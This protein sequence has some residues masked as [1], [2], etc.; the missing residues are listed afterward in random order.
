[1]SFPEDETEVGAP[2][3]PVTEMPPEYPDDEDGSNL[4]PCSVC[5]RTFN[6]TSLQRHEKVCE[7]LQA[8]KRN[9]FDSTKQRQ[10]G[11]DIP[12]TGLRAKNEK[13]DKRRKSRWREKHQEFLR[14]IRAAKGSS[15][16]GENDEDG[17][18]QRNIPSDYIQ[19]PHCER[20]FGPKAADRHISWCGEQKSRLPRT[21]TNED[22][23]AIQR[24]KTRT[25]YIPPKPGQNGWRAPKKR[26]VISSI[27]PSNVGPNITPPGRLITPPS[28]SQSYA[29]PHYSNR[30]Q[31]RHLS[32]PPLSPTR[33]SSSSSLPPG[34][35]RYGT[36]SLGRAAGKQFSSIL[37]SV[38]GCN[39]GYGVSS[40]YGTQSLYGSNSSHSSNNSH[41][42]FNRSASLR[43]PKKRSIAAGRMARH[44]DLASDMLA[45]VTLGGKAKREEPEGDEAS[46]MTPY[47]DRTPS[48]LDNA[49][50]DPFSAAEMQFQ[51]LLRPSKP[52]GNLRSDMMGSTNSLKHFGLKRFSPER[53]ISPAPL[54]PRSLMI[55][56]GSL[57]LCSLGLDSFDFNSCNARSPGDDSSE[58][59]SL[60]NSPRELN[61]PVNGVNDFLNRRLS[62][63]RNSGTKKYDDD[64]HTSSQY[65][66]RYN[67]RSRSVST[68]SNKSNVGS[69]DENKREDKVYSWR[70]SPT[71]PFNSSI[72]DSL[73]KR[74]PKELSPSRQII[75][76]TS[77]G[78]KT[79]IND[80]DSSSSSYNSAWTA[81]SDLLGSPKN[82][83][84]YLG[85]GRS[86][87]EQ[88]SG[89]SQSTSDSLKALRATL[90]EEMK[91]QKK[92]I[93]SLDDTQ[94]RVS[95][96]SSTDS[97]VLIQSSPTYS[98]VGK[99]RSS[100]HSS[101]PIFCYECGKKYPVDVAK[102]CCH[103]ECL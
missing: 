3:S 30:Q 34:P 49:P 55:G 38:T 10:D 67:S 72:F 14:T 18:P 48:K 81:N 62:P 57:S 90:D 5:N 21:H 16:D 86:F 69:T 96:S 76:K 51:D 52:G 29:S 47:Y 91:A 99:I 25:K 35:P 39:P 15:E 42:P 13:E 4:V 9:K 58:L 75:R 93:D 68:H 27:P 77:P 78:F 6:P 23:E 7:K 22:S 31:Q 26:D 61:S 85:G 100:T 1:M 87:R 60:N 71:P 64:G 17:S 63:S 24:L 11:L 28:P 32:P 94:Q 46:N 83:S 53:D 44:R 19:C 41:L 8:K 43:L 59:E 98:P 66:S 70:K 45:S 12:H 84:R 80:L 56:R 33:K 82:Y 65:G 74:S 103:C 89:S 95:S 73:N 2:L 102:F 40:G 20:Y 50:Y 37:A 36:G 79:T 54:K 101:L 97:S 88:P 92:T